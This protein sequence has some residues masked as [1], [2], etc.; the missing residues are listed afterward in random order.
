MHQTTRVPEQASRL[1]LLD[2][3]G[4]DKGEF[5]TLPLLSVAEEAV[6]DFIAR[7]K[8][9]MQSKDLI[10]TDKIEDIRIEVADASISWIPWLL[11]HDRGDMGAQKRNTVHLQ[12]L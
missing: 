6:G 3:L 7:V 10:V 1:A 8:E 5:T 9:N 2:S 12:Y 4:I 11:Y